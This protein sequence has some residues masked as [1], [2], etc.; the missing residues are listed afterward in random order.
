MYNDIKESDFNKIKTGA[1]VP[2]SLKNMYY[3][4][5]SFDSHTDRL[6]T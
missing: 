5:R 3:I 1:A 6:I 4:M 2:K